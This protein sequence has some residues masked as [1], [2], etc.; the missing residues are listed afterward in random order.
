MPAN[1]SRRPA[2]LRLTTIVSALGLVAT[3][4]VAGAPAASADALPPVI[5]EVMANPASAEDDWEWIELHNPGTVDIDLAGWVVDDNNGSAHAASNIAAGTIAAGGSAV[6]FNVDDVSAASFAAAW[7]DG[8]NLVPVSNWSAQALNNGGDTVGLWSSFADYD[9]DNEEQANAIVSV[10]YGG[11]SNGAS[12]YL[13]DLTDQSSFANSSDGT[14]T[15]VGDTYLSSPDGG[16]VGGEAGSPGGTVTPPPPTATDPV[17]SEIMYDANDEDDFEWVEVVNPSAVELDLAGWVFDDFNSVAQPAANIA[18][19]IVPVNGS[20]ILYNADDVTAADFEAAWGAGINLIAVTGWGNSAL[21]NGGD[22]IGLWS[23]FD[24]YDGDNVDQLN[25]VVSVTYPDIASNGQSI[26]LTDLADQG[27]FAASVD[28]VG[29]IV[30]ATYTSMNAG[31]NSGGDVGSPGGTFAGPEL[32]F[33]QYVEGSGSNKAIEISNLGSSPVSLDGY[34]LQLYSNGNTEP[35]STDALSGT[36]GGQ[37]VLV[38]YNSGADQAIIDVGDATSGAVNWNGDDAIVLVNPQGAVADSIGQVGFDPGSEWGNA[39]IGTQNATLCRNADVTTGDVDPTD[40]F[41]P[42]VEW[43]ALPSDDFTGLGEI[44]PCEEDPPPPA[45]DVLIHEVQGDGASSPLDGQNVTVQA[46]VTSMLE[47]D[48][49]L[50]GF[51]L[52]EEDAQ[53]DGNTNTSEGLFVFCRGNCPAGLAIGDQVTVTGV[54][55]EFNGSTQ[56]NMTSGT[57]VV[58]SSGNPLPTPASV[59]LPAPAGTDAE[60][61]FET[62]EGMLVEFVDKLIVSEYFQ[63][64]RFGEVV[65]TADTRPAQFTDGN[66]PSVAGY[67]AHLAEIA[68]RQIVLDDN[69]TS[70]NDRTSGP[71]SNEPY[72][73]PTPGLSLSNRFRGGDSITGLTGVLEWSFDQWRVRPVEILD[74]TFVSENPQQ[75]APDEVGGRLKVASFNVLNY[76]TTLDTGAS[77]CGPSGTLGCRGANSAAELARQRD[78]IISALA[79]IDA[80]IVG[81][82][83]IQNDDGASVADLVAA[84]NAEVGAGTYDYVDT[85]AIGGDAIKVAFIYKPATV[86]LEGSHAILDSSVDPTFIDTK[87]RPVLIQT[88]SETATGAALTVAV[89]HLKSKG[90]ACD[91]VGDPGLDDGQANCNLTR[92]SAATAMANYLATDPTGS[93]DSDYLIIGDLNAYAMEDPITALKNAGYVDLIDTFES[94]AY[95]FVFDGQTGYLDHALANSDLLPQVT[96][97]TTW[98]INADEVNLFDYNDDILDPGEQDFERESNALPI[99]ADDPFRSSDHDPLVVGLDLTGGV[100]PGPTCNGLDAT[101]VG[102]EGPD[103]LIGTNGPDVIVALGGND[104]ISGLG[105]DDV[106]CAGEGV[107]R[108]FANAGNDIIFGEGGN[109]RLYGAGGEDEIWGGPGRDIISGGT[110]SDVLHGEGDADRIY[111]SGGDDMAFGGDGNDI[112]VGGAGNDEMSGGAD[113]DSLNG[114]T[115]IDNLSGDDGDDRLIGGS[116]SDTLDGGADTDLLNGGNGPDTCVNGETNISCEL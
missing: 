67:A 38:L 114:G 27:S 49:A 59:D 17:I 18:A 24:D 76:F 34:V 30:G 4:L 11:T 14:P 92:T 101:I 46:I 42:A 90:S 84:L 53:V 57:A 109:D 73:Y 51:Y 102:T 55:D 29:T 20:A 100:E 37:D 15:P 106:I 97:V 71:L 6:L 39:Q 94:G 69:T 107:D 3:L 112:M 22:T 93:G 28:G 43:S 116:S 48:D 104:F 47:N 50:D 26:Y 16:N 58:D 111:G 56:I 64:A 9:G 91:D 13:T 78:K 45:G 86:G 113:N 95:S 108:V 5:S 105:G 2:R 32:F 61:T 77:I 23:S 80:D 25:A 63:L 62:I 36:V 33:S 96:G 31:G 72:A 82:V 66:A 1:P 89:N 88:F 40:V 8:I 99:Y 52:Q 115:G 41:D 70:S 44:G 110:E 21:N 35:N 74:Y 12:R 7:G 54:V 19:G 83:E 79:A 85:G 87:N 65:L 68:T 60:A 10:A 103:R 75:A 81:L 98:H